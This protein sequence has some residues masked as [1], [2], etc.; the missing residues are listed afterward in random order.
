V[1]FDDVEVR[2]LFRG[3]P[4][5]KVAWSEIKAVGVQIDESF[6]PASWWILSGG[7]KSGCL[8]PSEAKGSMKC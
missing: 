8:Y 7:A 2:V 1:Q 5:E 3:K 4:H 6:L